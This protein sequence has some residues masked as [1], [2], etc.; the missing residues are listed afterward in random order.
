M[1]VIAHHNIHDTESFWNITQEK[2]KKLPKELKLH[3][4]YP[5]ADLR[6]GTCIWEADS[7]HEIQTFIDEYSGRFSNNLC[8]EVNAEESFGLP[9]QKREKELV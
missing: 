5:S 8:Y 9:T 7:V 4:V 6:T 1:L 2:M 3:A